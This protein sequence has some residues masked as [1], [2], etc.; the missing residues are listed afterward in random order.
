MSCMYYNRDQPFRFIVSHIIDYMDAM[1]N[2]TPFW[3]TCRR[4]T[5]NTLIGMA[6]TSANEL[7]SISMGAVWDFLKLTA[8]YTSTSLD[9]ACKNT[10]LARIPQAT[11]ASVTSLQPDQNRHRLMKW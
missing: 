8:K 7:N 6:I 5:R 10:H 11:R 2:T 3:S 1:G 9:S 4:I